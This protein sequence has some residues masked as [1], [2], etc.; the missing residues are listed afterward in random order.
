M[1]L[2]DMVAWGIWGKGREWKGAKWGRGEM[3][4]DHQ[5]PSGLL[6]FI[7][8]QAQPYARTCLKFNISIFLVFIA[9]HAAGVGPDLG[10]ARCSN[11]GN[12]P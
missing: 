7:A 4:T 3:V 10:P 2:K 12:A 8:K 1:L 5:L 6:R 11:Q 9:A